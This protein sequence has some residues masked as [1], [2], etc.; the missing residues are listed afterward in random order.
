[1]MRDDDDARFPECATYDDDDARKAKLEQSFSDFA[2]DGDDDDYYNGSSDS[3]EEDKHSAGAAESS[4]QLGDQTYKAASSAAYRN[5]DDSFLKSVLSSMQ[6][7]SEERRKPTKKRPA[8]RTF[9]SDFKYKMEHMDAQL[10]TQQRLCAVSF[11]PL[12]LRQLS[13]WQLSPD[14][15][16]N[17]ED[18]IPTNVRL[19]CLEFNNQCSWSSN[20]ITEF[21]RLALL[22]L[23]DAY[24]AKAMASAHQQPRS[25]RKAQSQLSVDGTTEEWQCFGPCGQFVELQRMAKGSKTLC[26]PC[27]RKQTAEWKKTVKVSG[28]KRK[29]HTPL[30]SKH[31]HWMCFGCDEYKPEDQLAQ[32]SKTECKECS[33]KYHSASVNAELR[34]LLKSAIIHT[35]ARNEKIKERN[36]KECRNDPLLKC[37]ITLKDLVRLYEQQR[38]RCYYSNVSFQHRSLS[39]KGAVLS[40]LRQMSLERLDPRRGYELDN[41]RLICLGFQSTDTTRG[42]KHSNGGSGGWSKLKVQYLFKVRHGTC[43]Q[44]HCTGIIIVRVL[45]AQWWTERAAGASQPSVSWAQFKA[46]Q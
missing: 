20:D 10:L 28:S 11:L 36:K 27:A 23:D 17:D 25:Y 33:G 8:G 29:R 37:T 42:S 40:K 24:V 22:P 43:A 16:D 12:T 46:T 44:A 30:R 15:R 32:G 5:T 18:Y 34:R 1:M 41:V 35:E 31:G 4:G 13:D 19:V 14:R 6:K 39:A 9:K 21:H 26:K 45:C 38:A 2:N 7:H 3:D